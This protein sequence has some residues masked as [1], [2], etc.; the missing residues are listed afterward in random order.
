MGGSLRYNYENALSAQSFGAE[1]EIR[2]SLD[3]LGMRGLSLLLNATLI[4]SRVRF[5]ESG[6]VKTEDRE[7]QGQS[8]YIVNAGL[9]YQN[10]R[11]GLMLS[12]LYNRL[13]KR[14]IGIGKSNSCLLYTSPSPRDTR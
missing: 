8:P 3:F 7:M 13:G 5:D 1:V 4:K 11:W 9:Y 2:K 12:L 14:I 10:E 6:I